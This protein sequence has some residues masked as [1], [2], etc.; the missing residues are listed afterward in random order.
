[1]FDKFL[2][3]D[4]PQAEPPKKKGRPPLPDAL[5]KR[6][7]RVGERFDEKGRVKKEFRKRKDIAGK[8]HW[9]SKAK[10]R[11]EC[12]KRHRLKTGYR[13]HKKWQASMRR[14]YLQ[15]RSVNRLRAVRRGVDADAYYRLEYGEWL[16]LWAMAEDVFHPEK[17]LMSAVQAQNNP[18]KKNTTYARRLNEK[19]PF[20]RENMAIFWNGKPL[21]R[22]RV[23]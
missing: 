13:L 23:K 17:G 18:L 21:G 14:K 5:R 3:K 22:K 8:R 11:R 2:E 16:E 6:P 12:A 10:T 15:H 9:K 20:Y 7:K 4:I 1:M 19:E